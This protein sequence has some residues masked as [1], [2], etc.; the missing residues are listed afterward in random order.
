MPELA[1]LIPVTASPKLFPNDIQSHSRLTSNTPLG[2]FSKALMAWLHTMH[3]RLPS[4]LLHSETSQKSKKWWV[5]S[6][7]QH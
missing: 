7:G 5:I 1:Y 2:V 6:Q 3:A 4:W